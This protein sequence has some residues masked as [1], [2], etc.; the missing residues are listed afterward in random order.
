M[1]KSVIIGWIIIAAA[2]GIFLLLYLEGGRYNLKNP[3]IVKD[4]EGNEYKSIRIGGQVWMTENLR[5]T[6]ASDGSFVKS[7]LPNNSSSNVYKYGRLYTWRVAKIICPTDWHLP[8]DNDW[9]ILSNYLGSFAGAKMKDTLNWK[10][11]SKNTNNESFF[12]AL[13]AGYIDNSRNENFFGTKAFFWSS[14]ARD[15]SFAWCRILVNNSDSLKRSLDH[16][17]FAYSVRCVKN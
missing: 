16:S 8:S 12:T 13:P 4:V 3:T 6:R 14:T 2:I 15:T 1:S 11:L 5:T 7:F 10:S 9:K 17:S